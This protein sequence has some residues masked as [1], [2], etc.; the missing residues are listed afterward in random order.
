MPSFIASIEGDTESH[1]DALFKLI[2]EFSFEF[3]TGTDLLI[4]LRE[5]LKEAE[6]F[7]DEEMSSTKPPVVTVKADFDVFR[8]PMFKRDQPEIGAFAQASPENMAKLIIFV[9]CSQ[10]TEWPR[11]NALFPPFWDFLVTHNGVSAYYAANQDKHKHSHHLKLT[12]GSGHTSDELD[13]GLSWWMGRRKQIDFVWHSRS[14]IY[15]ALMRAVDE[16][17]KKGD[18]GF[19]VYRKM[20]LVPGLGVP[21]AGFA[22]Q[23]LI[24]KVGCIDSVNLNVLG[25][26]KPAHVMNAD[27]MGFKNASQV[28][29]P[30]SGQGVLTPG[31]YK[32][33]DQRS[34]QK[35]LLQFLYGELTNKSY[36]VLRGYADYLAD[37]EE[38]GTT[39]EVIWNVWCSVIAQKIIHFGG[40][41]IDVQLP[42]QKGTSQVK[43]YKLSSP[44]YLKAAQ[45]RL[46]PGN[47]HQSADVISQDHA[48]LIKGESVAQ[49]LDMMT[50]TP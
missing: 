19:L 5:A 23:L 2:E 7:P 44:K 48:R 33:I 35:E 34:E 40:K 25:V 38:K 27:G 20:I 21:K 31:E 49:F 50:H 36:E 1:S 43:S 46:D 11:L 14:Q 8:Y 24:G 22:T 16:D 18:T 45:S 17:S 47:M 39:S 30:T 41:P 3:G 15:S 28:S 10:Q 6:L 9:I 4:P 12:G 26:N 42:S 32:K 29:N 37:L 13:G